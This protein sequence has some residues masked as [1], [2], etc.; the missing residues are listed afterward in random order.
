MK[1]GSNIKC[2]L[3]THWPVYLLCMCSRE[4]FFCFCHDSEVISI[5]DKWIRLAH[6][7]LLSRFFKL[8]VDDVA[9]KVGKQREMTPPC[10]VPSVVLCT[11]S[12]S[13]LK[14]IQHGISLKK[15][16]LITFLP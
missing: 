2:V 10:G 3:F 16:R 6:H 11:M 13:I 5:A 7:M 9:D 14:K 12:S 4:F 8:L 1:Q 15:K